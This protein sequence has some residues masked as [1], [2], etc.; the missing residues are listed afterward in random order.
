MFRSFTV[1]DNGTFYHRQTAGRNDGYKGK[2][3]VR[4]TPEPTGND[5]SREYNRKTI[6]LLTRG[7]LHGIFILEY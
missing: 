7:K 3:G 2:T 1:S 4:E 6:R 5:G